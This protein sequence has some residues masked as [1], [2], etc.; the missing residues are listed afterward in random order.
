MCGVG[1]M[2]GETAPDEAAAAELTTAAALD[3]LESGVGSMTVADEDAAAALE[4]LDWAALDATLDAGVGTST[5]LMLSLDWAKAMAAEA[6]M[7][8]KVR[9]LIVLVLGGD[10]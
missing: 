9:M 8:A 4:T 2:T 3:L 7:R 6:V 1:T 10:E 5:D